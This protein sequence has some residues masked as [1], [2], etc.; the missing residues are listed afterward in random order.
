MADPSARSKA[1]AVSSAEPCSHCQRLEKNTA[2]TSPHGMLLSYHGDRGQNG[3][4]GERGRE[5]KYRQT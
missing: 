2:D 3:R 1:L 4:E 5:R